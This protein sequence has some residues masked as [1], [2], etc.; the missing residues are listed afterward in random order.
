MSDMSS[1]TKMTKENI[2][3]R[4]LKYIFSHYSKQQYFAGIKH[5]FERIQQES[6]LLNA[7]KIALFLK[8]F[9]ITNYNT[10]L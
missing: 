10:E 7:P 6:T 5:T 4:N 9:K 2:R 8:D 3:K 1:M